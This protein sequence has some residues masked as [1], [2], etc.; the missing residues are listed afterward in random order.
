MYQQIPIGLFESN[1]ESFKFHYHCCYLSLA[2][3]SDSSSGS[4]IWSLHYPR[5]ADAQL[6]LTC[7]AQLAFQVGDPVIRI[8]WINYRTL[9][10]VSCMAPWTAQF[11]SVYVGLPA[12]Y[13]IPK[14]GPVCNISGL[15][16]WSN[17]WL[18][19]HPASAKIHYFVK[20]HLACSSTLLKT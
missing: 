11:S 7:L 8:L 13:E 6:L 20:D 10:L 4:Q 18:Q 3:A 9:A 5:Y 1:T 12:L 16:L 17:P 15:F 14:T 19:Y 2:A